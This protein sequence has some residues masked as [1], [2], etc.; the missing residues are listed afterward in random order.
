LKKS[1]DTLIQ[2]YE[3]KIKLLEQDNNKLKKDIE[4]IVKEIQINSP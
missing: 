1:I 3:E 2:K 4:N